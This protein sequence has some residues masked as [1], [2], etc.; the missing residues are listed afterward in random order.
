MERV[1]LDVVGVRR[2]PRDSDGG[3][4]VAEQVHAIAGEMAA[5]GADAADF[6]DDVS[7]EGARTGGRE[8]PRFRGGQRLAEA[9]TNGSRNI[10]AAFEGGAGDAHQRAREPVQRTGSALG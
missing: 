3:Y 7:G 2:G 5:R 6:A 8:D 9:E 4:R 1:H 10:L